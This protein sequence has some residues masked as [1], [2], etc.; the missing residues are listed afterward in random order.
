MILFGFAESE[1]PAAT[2][3]ANPIPQ[4]WLQDVRNVMT[5]NYLRERGLSLKL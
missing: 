2:K 4:G 3:N 5:P 1:K